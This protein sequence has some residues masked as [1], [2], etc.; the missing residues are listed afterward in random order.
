[1]QAVS[2]ACLLLDAA[3]VIAFGLRYMLVREFMPYHA[4]VA[5]RT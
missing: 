2:T 3:G 1:M 5:G 4:V